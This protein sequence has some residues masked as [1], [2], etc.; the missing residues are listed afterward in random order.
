MTEPN[1]ILEYGQIII[2][3]V[4]GVIITW[5]WNRK[6]FALEQYKH[7]LD[8]YRYFD[9]SYHALL[10]LYRDNPKFGD[11]NNTKDYKNSF[12]EDEIQK[13]HYFAMS[14]HTVMEGLFDFYGES[15]PDEWK[16]IF[17]YHTNLHI[18]WLEENPCA[19]RTSY[20]DYVTHMAK[21][22]PKE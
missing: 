10:G 3:I 20:V 2:A 19:N 21:N 15:I 13:Y 8:K 12:A 1:L 9:E 16:N 22:K 7:H 11:E 5:Y 6:T 18:N 17:R 14:V 4:G